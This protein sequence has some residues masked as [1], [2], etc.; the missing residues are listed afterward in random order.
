MNSSFDGA[1]QRCLIFKKTY[2]RTGW[3]LESDT[4]RSNDLGLVRRENA[5]QLD[6]ERFL[7]KSESSLNLL[8]RDVLD[9]APKQ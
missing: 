8:V 6:A 7:L 1:S 2:L 4:I 9:S 3:H 5:L